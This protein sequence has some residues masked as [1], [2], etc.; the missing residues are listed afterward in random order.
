MVQEYGFT[1]AEAGNCFIAIALGLMLACLTHYV[2]D[3]LIYQK[4]REEAL[5]TGSATV[6][7]H[8][9]YVSLLASILLPVS[10]FCFAWSARSNIHWIVPVIG[11]TLFGWGVMGTFVSSPPSKLTFINY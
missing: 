1:L 11:I 5:R 6:P 8:R 2:A 10:L 7:E 3:R 4:K 9:L